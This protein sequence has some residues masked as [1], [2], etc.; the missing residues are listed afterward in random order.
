MVASAA[1]LVVV[2]LLFGA[3]APP[4]CSDTE[5]RAMYRDVETLATVEGRPSRDAAERLARAGGRAVAL[6]E[7]GL[8]TAE[9]PG[10]RRIARTLGETGSREA[11][12]ILRHLAAKDPDA[13]VRAAAEAALRS[14]PAE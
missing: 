3:C 6:L 2:V 14:L 7:T 10:R 8:Y 13:D 4:A 1:R 11:V 9:P 5:D 12:P